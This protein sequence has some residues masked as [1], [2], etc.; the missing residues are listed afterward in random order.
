MIVCDVN[1]IASM[2]IPGVHTE[3]AERIYAIDSDWVAPPLWRSEFASVL[4]NSVRTA[5]LKQTHADAAR[6]TRC[7]CGGSWTEA[8]PRYALRSAAT[9]D[10]A[11]QERSVSRKIVAE[12]PL[13]GLSFQ[14]TAIR[15]AAMSRVRHRPHLCFR[16]LFS[17]SAQTP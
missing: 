6:A 4:V 5:M 9:S 13:K 15:C 7:Q 11:A 14:A 12:V 17:Q 3:A 8:N 16:E 2:L 1:L 10:R